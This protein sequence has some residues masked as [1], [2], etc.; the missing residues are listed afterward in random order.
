MIADKQ[1][2]Q[3]YTSLFMRIIRQPT[4]GKPSKFSGLFP[5]DETS[6]W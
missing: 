2:Y 4:S 6:L 1:A 3:D 5:A